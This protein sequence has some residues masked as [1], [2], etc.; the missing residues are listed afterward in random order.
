MTLPESEYHGQF[1]IDLDTSGAWWLLWDRKNGCYIYAVPKTF[2]SFIE[3][4]MN[5]LNE[6]AD[7]ST[8]AKKLWSSDVAEIVDQYIVDVFKDIRDEAINRVNTKENS[9]G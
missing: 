3:G 1:T 4:L 7:N 5:K 2:K 8:V 6:R 9:D